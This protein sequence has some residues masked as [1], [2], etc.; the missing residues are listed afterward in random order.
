[1]RNIVVIGII[2]FICCSAAAQDSL[3]VSLIGS[4]YQSWE[5]ASSVVVENDHA[6]I[7]TGSEGLF[8]L[9][10]SDPTLP[11]ILGICDSVFAISIDI[12]GEYAYSISMGSGTLYVIDV[13]DPI[14]PH[15]VA[16]TTPYVDLYNP[17]DICVNG[18]Y[19]YVSEA[20]S[21][22]RVVDISDPL[23]PHTIGSIE[24]GN[25]ALEVDVEEN[26]AYV[27]KQVHENHYSLHAV[28]ISDPTSPTSAGVFDWT[29]YTSDFCVVGGHAYIAAEEGL[30]ILDVSD[31]GSISEVCFLD[32]IG[33]NSVDV[34]VIGNYAYITNSDS[35]LVVL[36]V[37]TPSQPVQTS[38]YDLYFPSWLS[39]S[40]LKVY[41]INDYQSLAIIDVA[42]P[43][44]PSLAGSY[45]APGLIIDL[46]VENGLACL[47][48]TNSGGLRLVDVNDPLIPQEIGNLGAPGH[49]EAIFREDD[50]VYLVG[51]DFGMQVIDISDPANPIEVSQCDDPEDATDILISGNY[52]YVADG[53]Y[54]LR[55]MDVS[56]PAT[57]FQLA[58]IS[59][60]G[61]A[62]GLAIQGELL[63]LAKVSASGGLSIF[64]LV[65]PALPEEIGTIDIYNA[66]KVAVDGNLAFVAADGG[67]FIV[68]VSDPSSPTEIGYYDSP[69]QA[70]DVSLFSDYAFI[71]DEYSGLR[72][73]DI[74][75]PTDPIE[76]GFYDL[77]SQALSVEVVDNFAYVAAIF[78]FYILDCS[79]AAPPPLIDIEL[80]AADQLVLPR[81]GNFEYQAT[82][83]SNLPS[84][85][86]VDIWTYVN[87]PNGDP[88]GPIWRIDNLPFTPNTMI[89]ADA[90]GQSIPNDAYLGSYTF[91]MNA[92]QFPHTVVGEDQ[93]TFEVVEATGRVDPF[94][95]PW[96]AWGYETAFNV[97]ENAD[98]HS[99]FVPTE[100]A[101][102]EAYPNPF[103]STTMVRISLPQAVDL[104]V[105]VFNT[106][107]QE[108]G[109]LVEGR[110]SAG[111]H[112]VPLDASTWS[113]GIYFIRAHVSGRLDATQ[114]IVLIK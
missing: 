3:N 19:A 87:L 32:G 114:K 15:V 63:F 4:L 11:S 24:T 55:V 14:H 73:I 35:G 7:A 102:S 53:H 10:V 109:R 80:V 101:F 99:S 60:S 1:M 54:D 111:I 46:S 26:Y 51:P 100:Y 50:L 66:R 91:H 58:L 56:N 82:V 98:N 57:P 88:Y 23:N 28:D 41:V 9:D 43:F 72:I 44:S 79:A 59:T 85:Y 40:S 38:N 34:Q 47:A 97:T 75:D 90:I 31:P 67:L 16:S 62:N 107:G 45:R 65:N 25:W 61:R 5:S 94:D 110:V 84:P 81:G 18:N 52:A 74:S 86:N 108:V 49:V 39:V 30:H 70:A 93:F 8:I 105:T 36:D 33:Q 92:G 112:D 71:A 68:D 13:S 2:A 22:M 76:T 37:S 69:D 48:T 113:S 20:Y 17:T 106:L 6:Y 89:H 42:D 27:L 77:P 29:D 64:S 103:N 78:S 104:K 21:E 95:Q 96:M 83:T 12:E